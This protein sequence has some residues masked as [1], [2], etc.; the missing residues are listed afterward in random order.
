MLFETTKSAAMERSFS[1]VWQR[2][3][4]INNN[5]ANE[6]TPGYKGKR[7]AFEGM[8]RA[9]IRHAENTMG[10]TRMQKVSYIENTQARVYNDP[11]LTVRADGNNVNL[12]N[13]QIE[14]ART[15]LQYQALRDKINGHYTALKYAITGGQ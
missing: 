10:A 14:L 4:L 3:Q 8:L 2:A 9:Q 15:Q 5:I 12:D 1:A 7:L 13:E 6:D 11:T